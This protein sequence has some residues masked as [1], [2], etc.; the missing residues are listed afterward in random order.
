MKKRLAIS[1]GVKILDQKTQEEGGCSTNPPASLRVKWNARVLKTGSGQIGPAHGSEPLSSTIPLSELVLARMALL[2][3]Q[4]RS[5]L[6][7][8]LGRARLL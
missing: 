5:V 7:F 1:Q 4:N 6:P 8:Q 2:M 3:D